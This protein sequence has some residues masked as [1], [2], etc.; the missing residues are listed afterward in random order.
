MRLLQKSEIDSRLAEEQRKRIDAGLAVA[1]KVDGLREQ[2]SETQQ[3]YAKYRTDALEAIQTEIDAKTA[4]LNTVQLKLDDVTKEWRRLQ[5]QVLAPL[6]LQFASFVRDE[7]K[8]L[9][10]EA[11]T[12]T[13][14]LSDLQKQ[15]NLLETRT[16]H[17]SESEQALEREKKALASRVAKAEK[18]LET[19]TTLEKEAATRLVE[20]QDGARRAVQEA[21]KV[22]E[23]A[24]KEHRA[25]LAERQKLDQ[26]KKELDERE[27]KLVLDE[28]KRSSPIQGVPFD[29]ITKQHKHG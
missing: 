13:T 14:G 16:K 7:R 26:W 2:L 23:A 8:K 5:E 12:L 21:K 9:D 27:L 17:L 6:E 4:E 25:L 22:R 18:A 19:T 1:R 10:A 20:A 15:K 11:Q 24:E 28:L 29:I 3:R